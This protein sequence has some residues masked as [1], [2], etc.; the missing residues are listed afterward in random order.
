MLGLVLLSSFVAAAQLSLDKPGRRR[1]K[2]SAVGFVY[3]DECTH[4]LRLNATLPP[5]PDVEVRVT[6]RDL[7]GS[8]TL[9]AVGFTNEQGAFSIPMDDIPSILGIAGCKASLVRSLNE[10]CDVASNVGSGQS[11]APLLLKSK[12]KSLKH[13]LFTTGP[14]AYHPSTTPTTCHQSFYPPLQHIR[15]YASPPP[16]PPL[17]EHATFSPPHSSP[18]PN[19]ISSPPASPPPPYRYTSSPPPY[20]RPPPESFKGHPPPLLSSPYPPHLSF[21]HF[22]H[23][24]RYYHHSPPPPPPSYY[25]SPPI[26]SPPSPQYPY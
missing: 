6:C 9:S 10:H 11:G 22:H 1:P 15:Y 12:S 24:H 13:V 26:H 19:S 8:V 7:Y 16:P 5:L 3:C 20:P 25:A 17:N 2:I 23:H 18:P 14:F 21:H 4:G